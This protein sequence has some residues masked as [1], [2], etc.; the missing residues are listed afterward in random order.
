VDV[1]VD[2]ALAINRR[3]AT[4]IQQKTEA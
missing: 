1:P 3:F 2:P 4:L